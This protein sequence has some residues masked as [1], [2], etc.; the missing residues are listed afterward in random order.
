[1][2]GNVFAV[3]DELRDV[4]QRFISPASSVVMDA[5]GLKRVQ[6]ALG[7][8]GDWGAWEVPTEFMPDGQLQTLAHR[9]C[10]IGQL[11]EDGTIDELRLAQAWTEIVRYGVVRSLVPAARGLPKPSTIV[12]ELKVL[13]RVTRPMLKN[14]FAPSCFWSQLSERD[15]PKGVGVVIS[16]NLRR[17]RDRGYISDCPAKDPVV[18]GEEAE[19]D[20]FGEESLDERIEQVKPW[21]PFPDKFTSECGWRSVYVIKVLGPT[22]LDAIEA[23]IEHKVPRRRD[24]V[25]LH[26]RRQQTSSAEVRDRIIA[27]WDWRMPDGE[28]L[29][30]LE[31]ELNIK[32]TRGRGMVKGQV[33]PKFA[34]PPKTFADAW[35]LLPILQGAHLFPVCLAS[36]PRASEVCSFT[37][38]CLVTTAGIGARI[39]GKTYKLVDGVEG[40]V[41]D[42]ACP[43]IVTTA[44]LQQIRLAALVKGRAGIAGNHLWVHIKTFGRGR[45]GEKQ[46]I[47]S[48][49]LH[50]YVCKLGI[51]GLL[52]DDSKVHVHRFR[53][54]LA[55]VVALSLVNA[56]SILMDCF[57][58]EDPEM[59]IRSYIL[60]NKQIAREVLIVQRELVVL[61]AVDIIDK[62]ENLG[63]A[64]GEQLRHRKAEF[65]QLLGKSEFE[66]KDAYEFAKRETYDGRT[67]MIVTPGVYCTIPTDEGG[68]CS[69]EQRGTNPAYCRGGCP[70]QLLTEYHKVRSDDAIS[71]IVRNLERAIDEDEPMMIAQWAGQLKNWLSRWPS[72]EDRWHSHPVVQKYGDIEV[73]IEK[74]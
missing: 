23:A 36:G 28:P 38:A 44:I 6:A 73:D 21:Q 68:L 67:W 61:M 65:L 32:Q 1:M 70:F 2:A 49:Q 31:I 3:Y 4:A 43:E 42:F 50:R 20:R 55:R 27:G 51:I 19:R 69:K 46:L 39:I 12:T 56:P 41:R 37:E 74:E 13:I 52:D 60:S 22:L 48:Q 24:G 18:I 47:I 66:P 35:T 54:T 29:A 59:T 17:Y 72:I 26:P 62:S 58:H 71:E 25:S 33:L 53:K 57:G 7:I 11:D 30:S 45:M 10:D 5:E 16:N 34:W 9:R 8:R 40:R 14:T 63:G 15:F 64:V